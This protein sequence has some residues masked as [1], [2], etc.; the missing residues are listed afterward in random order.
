MNNN[1]LISQL[2][3]ENKEKDIS[4]DSLK[5]QHNFIQ[6]KQKDKIYKLE[7]EIINLKNNL[8]NI[9]EIQDNYDHLMLKYKKL[10]NNLEEKEINDGLQSKIQLMNDIDEL[11]Q[12]NEFLLKSNELLKN[13]INKINQNT[14]IDKEKIKQLEIENKELIYE[15]NELNE[16]LQK[17]DLTKEEKE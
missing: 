17:I 5:S 8:K 2:K 3:T 11:K 13:E 15:K 1:I 9:K 7:E 14:L 6:K 10:K 12:K 4:I 16:K